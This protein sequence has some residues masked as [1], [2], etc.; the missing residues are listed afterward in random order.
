[1]SRA[2]SIA[3][4]LN[5]GL[6]SGFL[7]ARRA[8]DQPEIGDLVRGRADALGR[9]VVARHE[10]AVGYVE[11]SGTGVVAWCSVLAWQLWCDIDGEA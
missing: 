11:G 3:N 7:M 1:M 4:E 9:R 8:Q 5:D 10:D 2:I 6:H